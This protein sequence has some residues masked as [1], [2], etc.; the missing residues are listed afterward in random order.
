[1]TSAFAGLAPHSRVQETASVKT[2]IPTLGAKTMH[3]APVSG[4]LATSGD[5]ALVLGPCSYPIGPATGCGLL[6][7]SPF[8]SVE[9]TLSYSSVLPPGVLPLTTGQTISRM[10][11][12]C[13]SPTME[14]G[15]MGTLPTTTTTDG[16]EPMAPGGPCSSMPT[17]GSTCTYTPS[18]HVLGSPFCIPP[19]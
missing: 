13:P 10:L 15:P 1:M 4:Y 8:A 9:H 16:Y 2:T 5:K 12:T 18:N 3:A 17:P 19:Q 14:Q 11:P 7:A 6:H